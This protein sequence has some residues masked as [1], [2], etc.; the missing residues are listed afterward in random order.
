MKK[1]D[2]DAIQAVL[3][4]IRKELTD[5]RVE[6][7]RDPHAAFLARAA[8]LPTRLRDEARG[9]MNEKIAGVFERAAQTL[10][11]RTPE[12]IVDLAHRGAL[13]ILPYIGPKIAERLHAWLE[14][15][16]SAETLQRWASQVDGKPPKFTLTCKTCGKAFQSA[17]QQRPYCLDHFVCSF[18]DYFTGV[19]CRRVFPATNGGMALCEE[20]RIVTPQ[21]VAALEA[22]GADA[23]LARAILLADAVIKKAQ[24]ADPNAYRSG[25]PMQVR[26]RLAWER[27]MPAAM[28]PPVVAAG[29]AVASTRRV[30]HLRVVK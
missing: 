19:Q 2:H 10:E 6:E 24:L 27:F 5:A 11:T 20:H 25:D 13:T 18:T 16:A 8:R 1:P 26:T 7:A 21:Q 23:T 22:R 29:S 15:P 28:R 30:K 4:H 14:I 17:H 12:V 3:A 9:I